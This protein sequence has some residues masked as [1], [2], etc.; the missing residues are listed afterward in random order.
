M[1]KILIFLGHPLKIFFFH[2]TA[3][4]LSTFWVTRWFDPKNALLRHL[5]GGGTMYPPRPKY[6]KLDPIQGRVKS[7]PILDMWRHQNPSKSY[8][9]IKLSWFLSW[10]PDKSSW[11]MGLQTEYHPFG[12]KNYVIDFSS[13]SFTLKPLFNSTG[14]KKVWKCWICKD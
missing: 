6:V 8:K 12:S 14:W 3:Q 1:V 10:L 11:Q 2:F 5:T 7:N 9:M 13:F 4:N